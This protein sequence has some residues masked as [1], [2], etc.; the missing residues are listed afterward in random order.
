ML[1]PVLVVV[2]MMPPWP[3]LLELAPPIPPLLLEVVVEADAPDPC[4]ELPVELPPPHAAMPAATLRKSARAIPGREIVTA[5]P[6]GYRDAR[7]HQDR[8]DAARGAVRRA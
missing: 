7:P 6:R 1:L 8:P 2:N 3:P 4:V 5:I